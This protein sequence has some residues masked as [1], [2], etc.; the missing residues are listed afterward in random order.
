MNCN[1][2]TKGLSFKLINDCAD[3]NVPVFDLILAPMVFKFQEWFTP[4]GKASVGP[5]ELSAYYFNSKLSLWEPLIEPWNFELNV[6]YFIYFYFYFYFY[7]IFKLISIFK[8]S[9]LLNDDGTRG[10]NSSLTSKL[11][12]ELNLTHAFLDIV[13]V[14]STSIRSDLEVLFEKFSN[15]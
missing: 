5:V 11:R 8:I 15:L 7:F 10:Y 14:V 4:Q 3:Y 6:I 9:T 12:M 13:N 2:E 1:F